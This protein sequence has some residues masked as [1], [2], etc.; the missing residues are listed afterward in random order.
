MAY[1][2]IDDIRA[3]MPEEEILRLTDDE[4]LGVVV[5]SRLESV[6]TSADAYIDAYCGTRYEVPVS[7]VPELLR[8][9]SVDIAIYGLYSRM[10]AE[11]PEERA[12]R[13]RAAIWHLTEIS[14]GTVSLGIPVLPNALKM[15]DGAKSSTETD[16]KTFKRNTMEGY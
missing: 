13:H 15:V 9:L 10:V 5:E 2:T 11:M 3:Y 6:I 8:S 4:G 7:P 16:N 12:E 14:K 1:S